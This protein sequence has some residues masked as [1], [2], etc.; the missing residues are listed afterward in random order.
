MVAK[1]HSRLRT[2]SRATSSPSTLTATEGLHIEPVLVA[3]MPSGGRLACYQPVTTATTLR[4]GPSRDP[5]RVA[6]HAKLA[7]MEKEAATKPC[8][9]WSVGHYIHQGH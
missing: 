6:H 7:A 8:C 2:T 1:R 3:P 9:C 4:R 5:R